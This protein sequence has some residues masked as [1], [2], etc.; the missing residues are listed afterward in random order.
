MQLI[1]GN[2]WQIFLLIKNF[3]KD[4]LNLDFEPYIENV[5]Y[6]STSVRKHTQQ[7]IQV[8]YEVSSS[9]L[10]VLTLL[11]YAPKYLNLLLNRLCQCLYS[12]HSLRV[13]HELKKN[14]VLFYYIHNN[15]GI[16]EPEGQ[17]LANNST[18]S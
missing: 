17:I 8:K 10:Y 13:H 1:C 9:S 6:A 7:P 14:A 16:A 11:S 5:L 4:F 2:Q 3:D 12:V 15:L 18:L